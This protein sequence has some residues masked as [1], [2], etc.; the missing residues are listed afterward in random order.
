LD[1]EECTIH[2]GQCEDKFHTHCIEQW[3][4][5]LAKLNHSPNPDPR[6]SQCLIPYGSKDNETTEENQPTCSA[7]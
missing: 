1:H 3:V 5:K 7:D 6:C 4:R 2:I